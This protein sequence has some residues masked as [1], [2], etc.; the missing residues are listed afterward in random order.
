MT[1]LSG[2]RPGTFVRLVSFAALA[3]L[4]A[5][6]SSAAAQPGGSASAQPGGSASASPTAVPASPSPTPPRL[7]Y[8]PSAS[9]WDYSIPDATTGP[10]DRPFAVVDAASCDPSLVPEAS[11][12]PQGASTPSD[13]FFMNVPILMYHRIVPL[14]EAIDAL[15]SL[16]VPPET[17]ADQL[18]ALAAA[19]WHTITLAQLAEDLEAGVKP[20][21]R[22]FVITFDDGW[23]DGYRYALPILESRG[24]VGTY[25]VIASRIGYGEFLS[26]D[27]LRI[28]I[29]AGNEVASHTVDHVGLADKSDSTLTYEID[30]ASATI[31]S[32]TGVWPE[33]LAYPSGS[34]D[35]RAEL[36]VG[37]CTGMKMA[38]TTQAAIWESWPTRF[39]TPRIR[40][41][42]GTGA[43][44]LVGL[45]ES[46]IT[47][48]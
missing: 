41:S 10:S 44:S 7:L 24:M 34:F 45:L 18:A 39:E 5:S 36:A 31:A 47:G 9:S 6:C 4:A 48:G 1:R 27:Q 13:R 21:P 12:V 26:P 40:V 19:G 14:S 15:P 43:D 16:V 42:P 2:S 46:S 38:V 8:S 17:F 28:L 20:P 33:T 3:S 23:N 37:A 29:A 35:L 22:T 30:A 11:P 32:V 25:F